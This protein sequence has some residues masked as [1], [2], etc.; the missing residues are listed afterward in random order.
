MTC[1]QRSWDI[2]GATAETLVMLSCPVSCR[3]KPV[4]QKKGIS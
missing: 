3:L 4:V 1:V 2:D